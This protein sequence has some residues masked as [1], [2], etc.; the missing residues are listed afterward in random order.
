LNKS[1][2][3]D[4]PI[5]PHQSFSDAVFGNGDWTC[6]FCDLPNKSSSACCRVCTHPRYHEDSPPISRTAS[7]T[8][9]FDTSTGKV[10]M[11]E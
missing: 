7:D 1:K 3:S 2:F 9:V 10:F 11:T 4:S 6:R 8:S 5:D